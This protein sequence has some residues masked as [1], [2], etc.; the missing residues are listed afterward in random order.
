MSNQFLN[1][2]RGLKKQLSQYSLGS[3]PYI[4]DETAK[5]NN[6]FKNNLYYNTTSGSLQFVN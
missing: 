1:E 3:N 2:N 4:D 5:A 6:L